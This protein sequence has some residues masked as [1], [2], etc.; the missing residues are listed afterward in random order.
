MAAGLAAS[1]LYAF[2][3]ARPHFERALELWDAVAPAAG[4]LPLDRV[5]LLSRAAQACRLTGERQRAVALG[6]Q[7]LAELDHRAEPVRAAVLYER[8][9]E[10]HFWDD[11]TALDCYGRA[12]ALLP[13]GATRERARVLAAQG[14]ALMGL[15]R[16]HAAREHCESALAAALESGDE[17]AEAGA[18]ITLG[19]VLG[20][21]GDPCAGEI[22]L[23]RALDVASVGDQQA[24]A[25]VH[26]GE[27]Q[28][29]RGDHAGALETMGTGERAAARLGMRRSF[30][31][32]MYVNGTDDLFRLG[33]WDEAEQRLVEAERLDL[34]V[35]G[36]A[37]HHAI[38]GHLYALRGEVTVA[39][40]HLEQAL[41]LAGEPLP[42]EFVAPIRTAWAAL[43]FAENDAEGARRHVEAAFE[44]IGDQKDPLYTPPLHWLGVRAAGDLAELARAR[45]RD[46]ELAGARGRA[47]ALLAD[48]ATILEPSAAGA[49]PP[50]GLAYQALAVAEHGRVEGLPAPER[51]AAAASAFSAL[52]EPF[53]AAYARWREAEA[54]LAAGGY[55][56]AAAD[57]LAPPT[58]RRWSCARGRSK[59]S[60]RG[61]LGA[62]ASRSPYRR[63]RPPRT[64]G[65]TGD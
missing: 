10:S 31:H 38:A 65:T 44:A 62:R 1:R 9:G 2:A 28:R 21:L 56:A 55:R 32:F 17:P 8:L 45:R 6:R 60:S 59:R 51:W 29:L 35:T 16:W 12:L 4:A 33:R 22:H 36:A 34:D 5:E 58:P 54:G 49:A 18:R 63:Q 48:L 47:A 26:L 13:P 7:A 39:R 20:Y 46:A 61:S 42:A 19:L 50:D 15:R 14:H 27:L 37:L 41:A 25:Y 43:A 64:S 40:A 3:E 23:R 24:R 52:H 57:A 53:P 11:E 30:G